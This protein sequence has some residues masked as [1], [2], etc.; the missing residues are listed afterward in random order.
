MANVTRRGFVAGSA[1]AAGLLGLAGCNGNGGVTASDPLAAPAADKYP[2][3][4]DKEDTAAKWSSEE[5]RDGWTRYTNEGG[6]TLGVMD[7][8]KIIQVDGFAFKDLNGDGKLD[9]FEDW[10]QPA[11]DRAKALADVL[12]VEKILPLMWHGG[13]QTFTIPTDGGG[14]ILGDD[15]YELVGQG[16]RSGCSRLNA[17]IESYAGDIKWING[18]QERCEKEEWSIPYLNST[19]PYQL[20]DIPDNVTLAA[21]MDKDVWRKAGMWLGRAWSSTGVRCELGPQVDVYSNPIGCRLSGSICEDPA[22]NRDFAAAFA[23]GMQSTW[24]DDEATDDQ[25]WGKDSVATMFKHFVGEGSVEGG[26]N[27]H[28]DPGK[29]NVFPGDNFEAHLIPFLDGGLHLDSKTEQMAAIM[30]CYGITYDE[31]QKYGENVGSGYSKHN[32]GILRNAGWDGMITT[33]W[34]IL[35]SEIFG[36]E[37][38]TQPERYEK[39]VQAGIDQHGGSFDMEVGNAA[40]EL[41]KKD[42]GEEEATARVRESARRIFKVM[43][44]VQLFEQPYSDR[45]AAK[46]ILQNENAFKFGLEASEKSIVMLKNDGVISK[47][48][49]A[50]KPRVY[51][52]QKFTAASRGFMGMTPAS[53]APCFDL[54]T[55]GEVFDVVTDAVGEPTGPAME[56]AAGFPGA[57]GGQATEATKDPEPT[58]Q[59]SDLVRATAAD[60]ADVKYAVVRLRNPQSTG[61][62]PEDQFPPVSLQYRP[63][64][65]TTAREE[66]IAGN[67]EGSELNLVWDAKSGGTKQNRSYKGKTAIAT[68]EGDLDLVISVKQTLPEGAKLICVVDAANPMV[69]SEL[70]PYCDAI[71]VDFGFQHG[72]CDQAFVNIISGKT[73]PSGL[74]PFQ[75]PASMDTVE[76][77][78]EDV[79]RD[80]DCYVDADGN[81]YDFCFGLNWSGV[82]DDERTKTYKAAPL[83][84]VETCEVIPG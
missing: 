56:A 30:P 67:Q 8:A 59:E 22:V 6:A 44:D 25:G 38:K 81:T 70:E 23:G 75:M 33:D 42:L 27:D 20:F 73:E 47:D 14:P 48:C 68:N 45:D 9:F 64:T 49:M 83:T 41:L 21:A 1:L 55:A 26:R 4:P 2:I 52:P 53:I 57:P 80:M 72:A 11:A 69:F 46:E 7:T 13:L 32:L 18:A 82:I 78:L 76:A 15:E 37:D 36:V 29:F 40:W 3:E 84:K 71:L 74:L 16:S 31:D 54:D 19:D 65:A 58:Y 39:M 17:D 77:Q 61:A 28:Q 5:L 35:T 24:G 50:D 43:L 34:M 66:S 60:L 63:Y 10:R 79:P 12:P 51:I 62:D